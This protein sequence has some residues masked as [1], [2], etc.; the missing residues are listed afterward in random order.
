MT[1]FYNIYFYWHS[2]S[3]FFTVWND[4][5]K[6]FFEW[7]IYFRNCSF[8]N[9]IQ[10]IFNIIQIYQ[11]LFLRNKFFLILTPSEVFFQDIFPP[12]TIS[13]LYTMI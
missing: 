7:V 8:D 2:K 4:F 12:K 10:L 6:F 13:T 3:I 9:M 5:F 1:Y 11:Q